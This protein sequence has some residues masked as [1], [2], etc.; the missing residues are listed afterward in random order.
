MTKT[1]SVWLRPRWVFPHQCG[2]IPRSGYGYSSD[3]SVAGR[4]SE[5]SI[6]SKALYAYPFLLVFTPYH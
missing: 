5:G 6:E 4:Y 1:Y 2:C 3:E